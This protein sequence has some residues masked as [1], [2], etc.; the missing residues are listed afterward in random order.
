MSA[1]QELNAALKAAGAVTSIVGAGN[2][3][4][5]YPEL[6]P[7]EIDPPYIAYS[8]TGTE[9]T[10]TIHSSVPIGEDVTLDIWCMATTKAGA[11]ALA[12]AV[13]PAVGAAGFR[14]LG[15]AAVMP[16][17]E[18]DLIATSLTVTKYRPL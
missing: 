10:T 16:D 7:L 9:Y 13:I 1:E 5:I 15:R 11:D 3:A 8:R 6:I 17:A 2:S 18:R 12:S 14:L 4:R